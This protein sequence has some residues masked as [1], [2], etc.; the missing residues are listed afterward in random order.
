MHTDELYA[1]P[2]ARHRRERHLLLG[3]EAVLRLWARQCADLSAGGRARPRVLMAERPTPAAVSR[4]LQRARR[5]TIFYGVPTLYAAMLASADLPASATSW[6]CAAASRPARR[7][8][9]TSASAGRERYG[10]DILDGIGSTEMLHIFISQPAGRRALR[11]HRQAGARLR[12]A[13]SSTRTAA[14]SRARRDRRPAGPRADQRASMYWNNR[15]QAARDLPR[16]VDPHRR[17][18]P[19]GR[20]RLLRLLRPPRRH[21]QGRRHLGLAV[22]GRGGAASRIPTCSKPRSSARPTTTG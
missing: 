11:H 7:C 21:A 17:Q 3:G 20:R 13:S 6:R 12:A 8:R 18:I 16:P 19:R 2:G 14:R 5:P 22:R 9:R 15:E 10:V 4:V 1:R